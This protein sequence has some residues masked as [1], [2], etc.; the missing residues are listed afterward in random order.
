MRISPHMS[1]AISPPQEVLSAADSLIP[2]PTLQ[3][4]S[5]PCLS[6]YAPVARSPAPLSPLPQPRR[7]SLAHVPLPSRVQTLRPPRLPAHLQRSHEPPAAPGPAVAVA[8]DPGLLS[9]LSLVF[10]S[11]YRQGG[12]SAYPYGLPMVLVAAQRRA[13][14]REA[15]PT[16]RDG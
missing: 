11:A 1:E 2:P 3:R 14:L 6:P 15:S 4:R 9:P 5:V 7:Q 10:V 12:G 13:V 8:W 16:G